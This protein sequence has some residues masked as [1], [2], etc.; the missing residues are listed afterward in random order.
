MVRDA[1]VTDPLVALIRSQQGMAGRL[2]AEHADDGSDRCR[3]CSQGAQSGR[4][5]WPCAISL[6]ATQAASSS[7][8]TSVIRVVPPAPSLRRADG[9]T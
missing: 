7:G 1:P 5:S 9:V 3:V 8:R 6:A 2:L 4:Y